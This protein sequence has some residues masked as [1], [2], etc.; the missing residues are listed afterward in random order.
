[1]KDDAGYNF[2]NVTKYPTDQ[3]PDATLGIPA[4]AFVT[5]PRNGAKM[6]SLPHPGD[7]PL[8]P[9]DL[10]DAIASRRTIRS[11]TRDPI[12]LTALSSHLW[13]SFG[14][15]G[16][17]IMYR[18]APSAGAL[19]PVDTY[20]AVQQIEG[21]TPGVWRYHPDLHALELTAAGIAPVATLGRACMM[22]PAV[23][24]APVVFFWAATP[25]R[26]VWKYGLRGYRNIF[27]DAGHI[28]QNCY[29]A[30][31]QCRLGLCAIGAFYDDDAAA[32]LHLSADQHLL[33]AAACGVPREDSA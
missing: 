20:L 32:A 26:T 7:I 11:F 8:P 28:C 19:H 18:A 23:L 29:L 21:L 5:S 14:I 2:L 17:S 3:H 25:Y 4:P 22:Q 33:Y 1:M 31:E 10:R 16:D 9:L 12:P 13:A 15:T 6:I 27:L 24:R 30:A